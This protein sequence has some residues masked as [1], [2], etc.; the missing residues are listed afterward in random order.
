MTNEELALSLRQGDTGALETLWEQTKRLAFCTVRL[1]HPSVTADLDDLLQ[2]AFFGVRAAAFAYD[3]ERGSFAA[4]LPFFVRRECRKTLGLD[5]KAV[6]TTSLDAPL[7]DETEDTLEDLLADEALP[8]MTEDMEREELRR[9]VRAAVDALEERQALTVRGHWLEGQTIEQLAQTMGMTTEGAR[10]LEQR[11]FEHLRRDRV[12]RT[13][14]KPPEGCGRRE[15]GT[16]LH[17]FMTTGSSAVERIALRNAERERRQ[18]IRHV[19]EEYADD[20]ELA[21]RLIQ[22]YGTGAKG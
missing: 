1:Y 16:G 3:P 6:A 9:D 7:N 12:L 19:R 8:P 5:R 20:P 11:A 21:E 4:L 2:A 18:Y 22:A 17:A 13:L 15:P 14:Y 10:Q